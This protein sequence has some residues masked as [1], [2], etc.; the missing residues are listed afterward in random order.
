MEDA[1]ELAG[2]QGNTCSQRNRGRADTLGDIGSSS[3]DVATIVRVTCACIIAACAIAT[4]AQAETG[5]EARTYAP[6]HLNLQGGESIET[7][8]HRLLMRSDCELVL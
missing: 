4:V 3:A 1:N 2:R 5:L 7:S 8:G 6:G